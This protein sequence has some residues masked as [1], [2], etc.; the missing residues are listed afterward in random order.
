MAATQPE[1]IQPEQLPARLQWQ[2]LFDF[3]PAR[4]EARRAGRG[5]PA[6]PFLVLLKGLIYQRL[7][8]LRFLRQL[9]TQLIDRADLRAALGWDPYRRPPS[10]ERFSAFLS[11]TPNAELQSIRLHLVRDLL[12]LGAFEGQT[13]A[14]D[15][16]PIASWLRENNLKTNLHKVRWNKEHRCKG[17]PDARLG[18]SIHFPSPDKQRVD[19]FWGYRNH[20]LCDVDAELPIWEIT[21]PNSVGEV[22]VATQLLKAAKEQLKLPTQTV[23]ADS[24]YDAEAVLRYIQ[25]DMK[26]E[27][28]IPRR[29]GSVQNHEGFTRKGETVTCPAALTMN[30]KGRMTIKGITY[31]QYRCPF[32]YGHR[33]DLLG[34]PIG[35]PKFSEQQGCNYNWRLTDNPRDRI[36][37]HTARFKDQYRRR[38]SIERTF[39]RLLSTLIE[40]P[41]VR[42]VASIRNH[43]TITHI[44][45]LLVAKA[46]VSLGHSDRC[47]FARTFVPDLL[48]ER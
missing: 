16:C 18:V 34:C 6:V 36:A 10:L 33:P 4:E 47:R 2:K 15:S 13:V 17:D 42:G 5:R 25:K 35:H 26:A 29:Q 44:A 24:E 27:A 21:E 14:L 19:Y 41:T 1:L 30:R 38:L 11:D 12:D 37:Y 20:T 40:E 8:R 7:Q 22:T 39:S 46:A 9:H 48:V 3:L 45:T 23:L 28:I 32:Y 31:V 43:C